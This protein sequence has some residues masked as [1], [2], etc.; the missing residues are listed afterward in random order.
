MTTEVNAMNKTQIVAELENMVAARLFSGHQWLADPETCEAV[1]RKLIQMGLVE[2][3]CDEPRTWR[4]TPLGKELDVDLF[5]VFMGVWS[6]WE[7]PMILEDYHLIDEAEAEALYAS[8]EAD[9]E[10]LLIGYVKRAYSDY[11][12]AKADLIP[13]AA[14]FIDEHSSA[15]LS[16]R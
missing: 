2:V 5:H 12:K 9:A 6:E 16:A 8:E 14:H 10:S 4:K 13:A 11:H 15:D 7:V 1:H 3:V